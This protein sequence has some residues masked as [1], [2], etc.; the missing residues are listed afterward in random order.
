M[1]MEH[2][3]TYKEISLA[4]GVP[5]STVKLILKRFRSSDNPVPFTKKHTRPNRKVSDTC[6]GLIRDIQRQSKSFSLA[7]IKRELN[8]RNI[9]VS[10]STIHKYRHSLGFRKRKIYTVPILTDLHI[11]KRLAWCTLMRNHNW[12]RL[13]FTD[14]SVFEMNYHN[15]SIWYDDQTNFEEMQ[16]GYHQKNEKVMIAGIFT[17][18][19]KS[20]LQ[21]W[22]ITNL[23]P[24]EDERVDNI[25]YKRFLENV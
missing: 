13:A 24:S 10:K 3:K 23:R 12:K 14:E 1:R 7:Q 4:F 2:G 8:R 17:W 6:I 11:E 9:S 20:D 15:Q 21:I 16:R 18:R 22:K 5:Y 19:G 25:V